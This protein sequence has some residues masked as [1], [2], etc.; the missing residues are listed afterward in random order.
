MRPF[1]YLRAKSPAEAAALASQ[2]DGSRFIA[3]GTN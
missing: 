1:T 2:V 3:G